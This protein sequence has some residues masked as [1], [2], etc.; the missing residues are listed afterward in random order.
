VWIEARHRVSLKRDSPYEL[1]WLKWTGGATQAKDLTSNQAD[2]LPSFSILISATQF[3]VR[4]PQNNA[5]SGRKRGRR[6]RFVSN[7]IFQMIFERSPFLQRWKFPI[8]E[9]LLT[10][11]LKFNTP[12]LL[13]SE[14]N[15]GA[16]QIA[17][18]LLPS[19]LHLIRVVLTKGR[20]QKCNL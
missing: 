7:Q 18:N 2:I 13:P 6:K 11:F 16:R 9:R 4:L 19:S 15:S 10:Q 17:P 14:A 1:G 3:F 20:G 12:P 5:P 8:E